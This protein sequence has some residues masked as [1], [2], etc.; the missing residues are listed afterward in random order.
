MH[1]IGVK[2]ANGPVCRTSCRASL[3]DGGDDVQAQRIE[4]A[5]HAEQRALDTDLHGPD[6]CLSNACRNNAY[7]STILGLTNFVH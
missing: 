4:P 3:P 5:G 7:A 6:R 1:L 2:T